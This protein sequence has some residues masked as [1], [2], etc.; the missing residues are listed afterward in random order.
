[1]RPLHF[2]SFSGGRTS[3]YMTYRLLREEGHLWDFVVTFANT[4]REHPKTLDFVHRCDVEFGFKVVWLEAVIDLRDGYGTGHKVV[5]YETADREGRV[6]ESVIAKYGIP[7][8]KS[9]HCTR[10]MKTRTIESYCKQFGDI[11]NIPTAIGI[12]A[13]EKRRVRAPQPKP[14]T[15]IW[16]WSQV[17]AYRS[18]PPDHRPRVNVRY[19]LIEWDIEKRDVLRFWKEQ[20]FD[21]DIEEFEGN[22]VGCFKKSFDKHLKQIDRDPTAYDWHRRMEAE[23]PGHDKKPHRFFRGALSVDQLFEL[24]ADSRGHRMP[25][26]D[27]EENGGCSESC[28]FLPTGEE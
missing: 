3:A 2:I 21:L 15:T 20:S 17:D 16:L 6:F 22:C 19:P 13:D 24:H 26:F 11:R 12:R 14:E 10:E 27:R 9:P 28:E 7:S 1:M 4:G 23:Y 18:D 5:S 8:V 25:L